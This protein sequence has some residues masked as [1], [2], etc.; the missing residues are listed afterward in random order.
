MAT[1][2]GKRKKAPSKFWDAR[3]TIRG[4]RPSPQQIG[5]S[6]D[7][8]DAVKIVLLVDASLSRLLLARLGMSI[9]RL[10][11]GLRKRKRERGAEGGS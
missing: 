1:Y 7:S 8:Y 6:L 10:L 4:K 11:C 5:S 9:R 3:D 2:T